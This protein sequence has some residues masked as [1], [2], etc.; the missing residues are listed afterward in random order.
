MASIAELA[1]PCTLFL[2][3]SL[4]PPVGLAVTFYGIEIVGAVVLV[5]AVTVLNLLRSRDIVDA[6]RHPEVALA[7]E[8]GA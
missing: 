7:T 8:A 3:F 5:A 1:Y 6:P 4:P 2:V